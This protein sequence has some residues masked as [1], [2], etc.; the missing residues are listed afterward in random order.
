[1]PRRLANL[2][3]LVAVTALL[4]TGVAA[5]LLPEGAALPLYQTHRVAGIALVL[6]LVWKYAIARR[7]L[8]RRGLSRPGVWLG[9]A[10][11]LALAAAAGLGLAW[12]AGLVSF[13]R[14][15]SYSALNL[16][17]VAAL[18]LGALVVAHVLARGER[19]PPLTTLAGRRA[20][21][22]GIGLL[23]A[24]LVIS[25]GLDRV[26]LARRVTGSRHAGSFT[27]NVYPVTIWSFD[28]VPSVDVSAWRLRVR[29]AVASP[30]ELRYDELASLPRAEQSAILDCTG[31]W[32]TEQV[33]S[34]P[35]LGRLLAARGIADTAASVEV[36]SM[37][38]HRWSFDRGLAERA[39]LATH[40]GD[41]ALSAG[42][43]YPLRLVL[44]GLRGFT[45]VKWVQ[46]IVVV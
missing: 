40:V 17:V 33:W 14:P 21:L 20:A 32:W 46:D 36:V 3:L 34:G 22:R 8:R 39:I 16:H 41:D 29:G 31:G 25:T 4:V 12:T 37:T 24:S 13:D 7:S 26:A 35:S 9:L 23:A 10:T 6:A 5:W 2:A 11:A 27:G 19:R 28:S 44:P 30:G 45:W 42:H 38:G 1:M 43:G 15:L 18:V